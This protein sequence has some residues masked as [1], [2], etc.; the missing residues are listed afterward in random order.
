[1]S[2][3]TRIMGKYDQH[4][5]ASL[6]LNRTNTSNQDKDKGKTK[7][8]AHQLLNINCIASTLCVVL[9]CDLLFFSVPHVI[10]TSYSW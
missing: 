8:L 10:W 7:S 9:F 4:I 3:S 2:Y 1:M 5:I 6:K